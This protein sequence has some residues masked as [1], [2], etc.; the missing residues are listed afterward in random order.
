MRV[1]TLFIFL[2]ACE[3]WTLTELQRGIQILQMRCYRTIIGISYVEYITNDV[4]R[5]I[6][7]QERGLLEYLITTMK[8][9]KLKLYCCVIRAY[10]ISTIIFLFKQKSEEANRRNNWLTTSLTGKQGTKHWHATTTCADRCS[11]VRSDPMTTLGHRT[12]D[13]DNKLF[14]SLK[15][16]H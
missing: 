8:K 13:D 14:W 5:D 3:S 9:T 12:D 15:R 11:N 1:L 2:C 4:V 10:S 6:F 7:K 16:K